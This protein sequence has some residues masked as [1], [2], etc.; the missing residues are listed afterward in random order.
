LIDRKE[1][2]GVGLAYSTE[3]SNH[4]LN[5]LSGRMSAFEDQPHHFVDWMQRQSAHILNG[6]PVAESAFVPRRMYGAYLRDLLGAVKPAPEMLHDEVVAIE[7]N[8][9][10]F[11]LRCASRQILSA[12]L[13]VLATGN[14]RPATPDVPGLRDAPFWRPDPWRMDA[15][16]GLDP[17]L[18]ILLIGTGPTAV[19]AVITLLDQG[20]VGPIYAVSRR[21]LLPRRHAAGAI[22]P[23]QLQLPLHAGL[24]ELTCFVRQD[25]CRLGLDVTRTGALINRTGTVSRSLFALGPPTR[26]AF[27]DITA[28]PVI[29]RQSEILARH[30]ANLTREQAA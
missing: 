4:L 23:I 25:E 20:H 17:R 27:W 24:G 28:I 14:D 3:N 10:L 8:D 9:G 26:G 1:Q 7:V 11:L 6:A 18:P 16:S 29:R 15:F 13:V 22:L 30:L 12:N 2:F 21:G 5:V 19:D